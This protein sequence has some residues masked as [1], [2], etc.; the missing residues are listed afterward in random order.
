VYKGQA[1]KTAEIL[2]LQVAGIDLL[3]DENGYTICEANSFPGFKGLES[4]CDVNIPR[5][6]FESMQTRID[7]GNQQELKIT[8]AEFEAMRA[9][10]L[11]E[12]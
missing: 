5:V 2:N 7:R 11:Q 4:C 3:Y 6:I 10:R 9:A 1:V 8:F 12:N